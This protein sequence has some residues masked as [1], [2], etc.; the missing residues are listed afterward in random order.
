MPLRIIRQDITKM[1]V[2]AIVNAANESLLGGGGVDGAIHKAAG[3]KL[4]AECK[5]LGGCEVG[6]VKSTLGYNLPAKHIIH[7]VGPIYNDG[8]HGEEELLVSCYEQALCEA[9]RL[10]C[11]SIAFPLISSGAFCY[12]KKEALRIAMKTITDFL[13]ENSM[14]IYICIW[15]DEVVEIAQNLY[16]DLEQFISDNYVKEHTEETE[17]RFRKRMSTEKAFRLSR[18]SAENSSV[19]SKK[20]RSW[21]NWGDEITKD[22]VSKQVSIKYENRFPEFLKRL[23]REK[24]VKARD[25][26]THSNLQKQLYYKLYD[27]NYHMEK[28][29]VLALAFGLQLDKIELEALLNSAGYIYSNSDA[30]DIIVHY[31]I[32]RRNY[33][34][35]TLNA[36]LE[37][38]NLIPLGTKPRRQK[39][40]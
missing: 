17:E 36:L 37:I 2:D 10:G 15:S 25:V 39:K 9:K 11:K 26:W 4:L 38:R 13:F 35:Y 31:F 14:E 1:S 16:P 24:G 5:T 6:C 33:N 34:I 8:L 18:S 12:P 23:M 30:R 32:D 19:T 40:K 7:A 20:I 29:T 28:G 21:I 27:K 22:E 3:E